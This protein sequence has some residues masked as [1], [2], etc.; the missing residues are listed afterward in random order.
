MSMNVGL[1]GCGNISDIYL[2]N[3]PRFADFRFVACADL[4]PAAAAAKAAKYGIAARTVPELLASKDVDIVLNLTIPTAHA[5]VCLAALDHGKHVYVE[6]PL[7]TSRAECR[8]ILAKASATGLRVGSAPDTVLGANVQRAR[9]LLE[10]GAIGKP[11]VAHAAIL[12]HGMEMW[13]PAPEFFYKPGG[14]PVLDMGPYY[15]ATLVT[16]LGA[17]KSVTAQAQIGNAYRTVTTPNCANTG[18][19]ILV[20]TPTTFQAMLEFDSGAQATLHA[21]WDVWRHSQPHL[22]FHGTEGSMQLPFPNWF[23]DKILLSTAGADWSQIDT[24][25]DVFGRP[26]YPTHAGSVAN[27]RGLGLADMARAIAE[28]RPHRSSGEFGFHIFDVLRSI[29]DSAETGQRIVLGTTIGPIASMTEA[30]AAT[31][32]AA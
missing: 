24:A 26:N 15:V 19:K 4:V 28:G 16:L 31:Y 22:E 30:E 17:V 18:Q 13:H 3:A 25:A 8:A 14:G 6:K 20:E 11:L 27:Y 21:S 23:G 12:D 5:E 32:L 29:L 2:S 1:I 7:A 10:A 9:A